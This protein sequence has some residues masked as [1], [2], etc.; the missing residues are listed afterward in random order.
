MATVECQCGRLGLLGQRLWG[1]KPDHLWLSEHY[2]LIYAARW[3]DMHK[4]HVGT[5]GNELC[6]GAVMQKLLARYGSLGKFFE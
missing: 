4:F 2:G 1:F 5:R 6:E 3:G